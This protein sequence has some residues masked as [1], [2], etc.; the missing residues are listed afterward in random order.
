M[1]KSKPSPSKLKPEKSKVKPEIPKTKYEPVKL[2]QDQNKPKPDLVETS[3]KAALKK[4]IS[5]PELKP[6]LMY[7]RRNQLIS[8]AIDHHRVFI[9][10][11]RE[12]FFA[13]E[14]VLRLAFQLWKIDK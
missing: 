5:K 2:N 7:S 6:K 3:L 8:Q 4:S 13:P 9:R 1:S 11:T 14:I 10:K 12:R